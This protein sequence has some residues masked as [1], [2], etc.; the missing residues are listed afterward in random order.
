MIFLKIYIDYVLLIN[1]FFDFILLVAISILLKNNTS[2][3]K[4]I[5]AS[6]FGSLTMF[7]LFI[8]FNSIL[9]FIVKILFGIIMVIICFSFKSIKYTLNNLFYLIILSI[10]LGG[11]I[12]FLNISMG[13]EHVGL[14]F[15]TNG[16]RF[17]IIILF[18]LSIF[19]IYFYIKK[20]KELK[21]DMNYRY[22]V[23][24]YL[25]NK[26]L[27]LNGYL[28]SGNSLIDPYFNKPVLIVSPK[29]K[30]FSK[31]IYYVPY[32]GINGSGIL[33]CFLIKKIVI[34]NYGI[35]KDVMVASS[36]DDFAING[37]DI[38][39]NKNLFLK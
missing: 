2:L 35:L 29:Y 31:K 9:F 21:I 34:E 27:K 37:V 1:F 14:I 28:D 7:I 8:D 5:M 24:L 38:I 10:I 39:L 12:Y 26:V 22:K 20:T 23:T 18:I 25:K 4:I 15:F 19:L 30:L 13:Y 3:L 36:K 11:F 32:K 6:I 16:K 33:K 17:N